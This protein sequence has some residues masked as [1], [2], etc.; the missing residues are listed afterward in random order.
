MGEV[1]TTTSAPSSTCKWQR[2]GGTASTAKRHSSARACKCALRVHTGQ[3]HLSASGG[4]LCRTLFERRSGERVR[5]QA[6]QQ[7]EVHYTKHAQAER[8]KRV[9]TAARLSAAAHTEAR[10]GKAAAPPFAAASSSPPR[11]ERAAPD[12]RAA[13]ANH[14]VQLEPAEARA[15]RKR[16]SVVLAC[17]AAPH[18]SVAGAPRTAREA[19][20]PRQQGLANHGPCAERALRPSAC[21]RGAALA[22]CSGWAAL[23]RSSR[24]CVSEHAA[25]EWL[26]QGR[27]TL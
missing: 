20:A 5:A 19:A 7:P 3:R 11:E 6:Q 14:D 12:A 8:P 2:S 1:R 27:R 13:G 25:R 4:R 16:C 24:P 22:S 9:A 15:D 26:A 10:E 21:W 23:R 18:V 17:D